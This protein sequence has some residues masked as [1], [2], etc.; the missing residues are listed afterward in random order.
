MPAFG[1]IYPI[2]FATSQCDMLLNPPLMQVITRSGEVPGSRRQQPAVIG[3]S[4]HIHSRPRPEF[5]NV[6]HVIEIGIVGGQR[7]SAMNPY[8]LELELAIRPGGH[9]AP[10]LDSL[11]AVYFAARMWSHELRR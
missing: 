10:G 8:V 9:D 4:G 6:A 1:P 3:I 2:G 11:R 7:E 5:E